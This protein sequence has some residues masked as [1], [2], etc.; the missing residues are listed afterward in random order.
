MP[1]SYIYSSNMQY[2]TCTS[3][4]VYSLISPVQI[5]KSA[6]IVT[7]QSHKS[8][9]IVTLQSQSTSQK[10]QSLKFYQSHQLQCS[11]T[12][13]VIHYNVRKKVC[14]VKS[15]VQSPK[16]SPKSQVQVPKSKVKSKVQSQVQNLKSKSQSPKSQVPKSKF[17]EVL[18]KV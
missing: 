8:T 12:M 13:S 10:S 3:L 18:Q 4:Y 5:W 11:T 7:L 14:F 6:S 15:K 17:S 2:P 16:S 9:S 1:I